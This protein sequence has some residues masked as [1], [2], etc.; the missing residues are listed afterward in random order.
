M[1]VV[2]CS[3][4]NPTAPNQE[5]SA[6]PTPVISRSDLSDAQT[7]IGILGLYELSVDPSTMDVSLT[8]KRS[9]AVGESYIVSGSGFFTAAPCKTCLQVVGYDISPDGAF[10]IKFSLSHPFPKGTGTVPSAANRLDL[11]IFDVALVLA[12]IGMTP[13]AYTLS[14]ANVYTGFA[15]G[16]DGYTTE[17]ANVIPDT[18]AL[19]Y[20]L[21]ID[22]TDGTTVTNNK[23]EMGATG[24]EFG[25]GL[26]LT[27]PVVF[28]TYLTFGYG[29]SAKKMQRLT[30]KYYLPEFNRKAAW[31]IN[32]I[33]PQGTATPTQ[34][35]TWNNLYNLAT[36]FN[37]TVEVYDWQQTAAVSATVPY[38]DEADTTK[39]FAESK[40]SAVSLEIPGMTT[41]LPVV[42]APTGTGTP[43]DPLVYVVPVANELALPVGVY[44]GLVTVTDTRATGTST[45]GGENDTLVDTP[46]G[47]ALNWFSMPAFVTYQ[48]FPATVAQG[49]A[50]PV[51]NAVVVG[52]NTTIEG[53]TLSFDASTST[54]SD[55]TIVLYE[56]DFDGDGTFG[57]AYTGSPATPTASYAT[58][59]NFNVQ[60]KVTDNLGETD[61][62][63]A[64]LP[65]VIISRFNI[66]MRTGVTIQDICT[67]AN[68][69]SV[70]V[71]YS[72]RQ[73]WKYNKYMGA[74]A[75]YF[76]GLGN[77]TD[78]RM[79]DSS[80]DGHVFYSYTDSASYNYHAWYTAS[81]GA[82][83]C[84]F[85]SWS[86]AP[87][88]TS[89]GFTVNT[90]G[91][92]YQAYSGANQGIFGS[93]SYGC[94]GG[95]SIYT[96]FPDTY[97]AMSSMRIRA[98]GQY[99]GAYCWY[100]EPTLYRFRYAQQLS[101]YGTWGSFGDGA[102]QFNNP[103]D[104]TVNSNN[105]SIYIIDTLS[106][107]DRRIKKFNGTTGAS[108]GVFG[109]NTQM[110]TA[111]KFCD[112][113]T[114]N[115]YLYVAMDNAVSIFTPADGV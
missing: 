58:V 102:S 37:V 82:L 110:A 108:G 75:L 1:I 23:F 53:T 66:A 85:T 109:T 94:G 90:G 105:T 50:K 55:G 7:G 114:T 54:D 59:G 30:P 72:D 78:K 8:S 86:Y 41:A 97:L 33:P 28:D 106:T 70:L 89:I 3:G 56:W 64:A 31:K 77:N 67:T 46:D 9:S 113:L 40:V 19:P 26:K 57:D 112:L 13:T 76:T 99:V 103:Q 17:L 15:S 18:T 69:E 84:Q 20:F 74:G 111:P 104:L 6:S 96:G 81:T 47:I 61:T 48:T 35:N 36:T 80:T 98:H 32:V 93:I 65:V 21:A 2:G 92:M 51:A 29:A 22:D 34:Y 63:N 39:V 83:Y 5:G 25:V 43:S 45:V 10:V 49:N 38:S 16:A 14:A 79:M 68:N 71:M 52:S 107:G 91:Q 88:G 115:N 11:D 87:F 44:T 100:L 4:G 12:P 73:V 101:F 27:G 42:P 95:G 60:L 24:V 62:L